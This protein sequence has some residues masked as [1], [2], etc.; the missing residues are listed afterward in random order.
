LR[1]KTKREKKQKHVQQ[2]QQ[3]PQ[4]QQAAINQT[5][6]QLFPPSF[7]T[8]LSRSIFTANYLACTS[9]DSNMNITTVTR[10]VRRGAAFWDL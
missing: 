9:M 4:Q 1:Q 3:E 7:F 8:N 2:Q 5:G 10:G 6:N